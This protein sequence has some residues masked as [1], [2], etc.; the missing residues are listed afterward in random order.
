MDNL[1]AEFTEMIGLLKPKLIF[2]KDGLSDGLNDVWDVY[3]PSISTQVLDSEQ[4]RNVYAE[5]FELSAGKEPG[6]EEVLSLRMILLKTML[7]NYKGGPLD[8][9]MMPY[10][11]A[12]MGERIDVDMPVEDMVDFVVRYV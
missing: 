5:E 12:W 9:Q 10:D 2:P 7:A 4:H 6:P 8:E 11:A 1:Q 3:K